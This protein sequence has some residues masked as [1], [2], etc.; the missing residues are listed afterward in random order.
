MPLVIETIPANEIAPSRVNGFPRGRKA[1][2]GARRVLM[3][4]TALGFS[5]AILAAAG[6]AEAACVVGPTTVTCADP[7]YNGDITES[8]VGD[9]TLV[10]ADGVQVNGA[11]AVRGDNL[12]I[13]ATGAVIDSATAGVVTYGLESV[14]IT[15]TD[16]TA[17][18]GVGILAVGLG[19]VIVNSG[20]VSTIGYGSGILA[21]G[22]STDGVTVVSAE[23]ETLGDNSQGIFVLSQGDVSITSGAVTTSGESAHG[24]RVYGQQDVVI[25]SGT[26]STSSNRSHGI[27]AYGLGD[28]TITSGEI[29]TAGDGADAIEVISQGDASIASGAITTTGDYSSG[30]QVYGRQDIVVDSGTI[31]TTGYASYGMNING[32]GDIVVTSGRVTTIGEYADG[33]DIDNYSLTGLVSV[34]SGVISTEGYDSFG[35]D[36]DAYGDVIV[37]SGTLSTLGDDADGIDVSTSGDVTITSSV[38]ST[39]G[40]SS[41]GIDVSTDGDVSVTSGALSTLGDGSEGIDVS[42]D[43]SVNIVSQSLTTAGRD[44]EGMDIGADGDVMITSGSVGT[45]G[46]GSEG[47]D[48][49]AYGSVTIVSESV[50]TAGDYAAAMFI[51]ADG[52][53]TITSG[54][55]ATSGSYAHGMDIDALGAVTIASSVI[56]TEGDYS[57]GLRVYWADSLTVESGAI[58]TSGDGSSGIAAFVTGDITINS[59]T[60]VTSGYLSSGIS[61]VSDGGDVSITAASVTTSG[62][63]S[64]GVF[65]VVTGGDIAVAAGS[66]TTSGSN[67]HG[68]W[69]YTTGGD[70]SVEVSGDIASAQGAGILAQGDAVTV[71]VA[72]GAT[73]TGAVNGVWAIS[74]KS[75]TINLAG[76]VRSSGGFAILTQG[77]ATTINN[78]GNTIIGAIAL[79]EADD[80][81]NNSGSF[82]AAGDSWFGGGAD[83]FNNSGLLRFVD[84]AVPA[85]VG[86]MDLEVF[87]N[88]GVINLGNGVVGDVLDLSGSVFNGLAGSRLVVDANGVSSDMLLVA[89]ATGVTTVT[90]S[91]TSDVAIGEFATFVRSS[92]VETGTEFVIDGAQ[93]GLIGYD[94][95]FDA[96]DNSF[97]VTGRAGLHALDPLRFV[98]GAQNLWHKGADGW[99]ARMNEVRDTAS[100]R[101]DG[102]EAW[103]QTVFGSDQFGSGPRSYAAFDSD[104]VADLSYDQ[105]YIGFTAG[106]DVRRSSE[107]GSTLWGVTTGLMRSKIDLES[108]TSAKYSGYNLGAYAGL[109]RDAFFVNAL[110]RMD[111][112]KLD[113][114]IPAVPAY[115]SVDGVNFG[116]KVEAGARFEGGRWFAEPLARLAWVETDL[117]G[118]SVDGGDFDYEKGSSL[119][120]ELGLRVGAKY[121]AGPGVSLAPHFALFAVEELEGDNEMRLTLGSVVDTLVDTPAERH[122]RAE[123]GVT[124]WAPKGLEAFAQAEALFGDDAEGFT[125]RAGVRWRF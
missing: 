19:E 125:A 86:F 4:G 15:T 96:A 87:N 107:R 111:G 78:T 22:Y 46:Y 97:A 58:T 8:A 37:D 89:D 80:V 35:I 85:A 104:V 67:A 17:R 56:S 120:A 6:S 29:A 114:M 83:V 93:R 2:P 68:V 61:A 50:T 49:S 70:V 113:A 5:I 77:G 99:S 122:G 57:S 82:I 26:I 51:G 10:I 44:A 109:T 9:L 48:V 69:G 110:V 16:V 115:E 79:S 25:D 1:S 45:L 91:D 62:Q 116:A 66:I 31:S 11:V 124:V 38:L 101:P 59:D 32:D 94:V 3:I 103:A 95:V 72:E 119:K 23:V 20:A 76:S 118:F 14:T 64:H 33:I 71:T 41:I 24:M 73:V 52:D 108:A 123:V 12:V 47:I 98:D 42:T 13:D 102:L 84:S 54:S 63:T 27:T 121:R 28:V 21:V 112:Y 53:V 117:D 92:S 30:M 34:S 75:T 65:A 7:V 74:T 81:V 36:I 40:Y 100:L 39:A 88:S 60:V 90:V 55:I 106:F 18:D 105:D 43:G